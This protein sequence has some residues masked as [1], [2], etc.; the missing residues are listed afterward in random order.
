MNYNFLIKPLFF[1]CSLIFASW[2][3]LQIEKIRPSDFGRHAALF[4]R[5]VKHENNSKK[6]K[7]NM[8][9]L[10]DQYKKGLIDSAAFHRK[11]EKYIEEL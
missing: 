7:E 1:I 4:E 9:K 10:C 2:M 6:N 5:N 3:V 8:K 11:L